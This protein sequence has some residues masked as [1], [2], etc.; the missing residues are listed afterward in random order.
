MEKG[1]ILRLRTVRDYGLNSR[2]YFEFVPDRERARDLKRVF[3]AI[4]LG[5]EAFE[6][7]DK[8]GNQKMARLN[9][10]REM[11]RL[12]WWS[13]EQMKDA[14]KK[15]APNTIERLRKWFNKQYTKMVA[16][17]AEARK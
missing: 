5:T 9:V 1:H 3:V 8:H 2:N 11:N 12:G 16:A 4:Y 10:E 7:E 15:S 13:E 6:I 14:L 17:A